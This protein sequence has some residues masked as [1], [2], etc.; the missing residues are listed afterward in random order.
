MYTGSRSKNSIFFE[1]LR[2]GSGHLMSSRLSI[3]WSN[4]AGRHYPGTTVHNNTTP[5]LTFY[6]GTTVHNNATPTLTFVAPNELGTVARISLLL[7]LTTCGLL[8]FYARNISLNATE[9]RT[10][11][12]MVHV[13]HTRVRGMRPAKTRLAKDHSPLPWLDISLLKFLMFV[14]HGSK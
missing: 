11:K 9:G 3:R 14:G 5:T 13:Q 2:C 7:F 4:R 8:R 12:W 6:L 1:D 10:S